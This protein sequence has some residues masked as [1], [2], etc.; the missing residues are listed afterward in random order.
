MKW[1]E[2]SL[3]NRLLAAFVAPTLVLVALYG[4]LA[5]RVAR[6]GLEDELSARVLAVGQVIAS[7]LVGVQ[8][9]QIARLDPSMSRVQ[10][11]LRDRLESA[12]Q[13][14]GVRRV[15]I[16]NAERQALVDTAPK[17][18][19]HQ[20]LYSLDA[21]RLEVERA[22]E[23]GE[24]TSSVLFRGQDGQMVKTAYAPLFLD[25]TGA[26]VVAVIGVEASASY[27]A[28]L[29]QFASALSML[30]LIGLAAAACV[31]VLVAR[32]ITRPVNALVEA[33]RRLGRGELEQPVVVSAIAPEQRDELAFLASTFEEMR[34]NLLGRDR[35]MQLMLSGIAHEVRNPLGGMELFCGLLHEDLQGEADTEVGR[36]RLDRVGRIQRELS[37]LNSVVNDFLDFARHQPLNRQRV[38][39]QALLCEVQS[40]LC[41]EVE[42]AGCQL[43]IEVEPPELE[44]TLDPDRLRRALLNAV[45]NAHQASSSGG[46]ITLRARARGED[47]RELEVC[48]EG[49]GMT[50]EQLEEVLTPFFTT[51]EKGTGL[52]LTLTQKV[53]AQHGGALSIDSAP[54][55]GTTVRFVLPFHEDITAT[56]EDSAQIIPQGW[57]G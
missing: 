51:K 10:E 47:V 13:A 20:R 50:P 21:D 40:L 11:R 22:F 52:G 24:G 48:D 12:R 2:Q 55:R 49:V 53:V 45:R 16:F 19:F 54:G 31:G 8:A 36:A 44:L 57:L 14:S 37:Y 29:T 17:T 26:E 6:A 1:L 43:T 3:L 18:T 39:A 23:R 9:D 28:L 4:V 46:Q 25:E 42:G 5:Y 27:F 38:S 15:F 30:G 35:Q 33:A 56:Q 41:A 34:L 7:Q 32:R